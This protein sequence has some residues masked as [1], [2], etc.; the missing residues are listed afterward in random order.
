MFNFL[1]RMHLLGSEAGMAFVNFVI[2]NQPQASCPQYSSSR[3]K[4]CK[5]TISSPVPTTELPY[6]FR[7]SRW[8]LTDNL[9]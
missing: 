8:S 3:V 2:A 5:P 6:L 7:M 4:Y 9:I 1:K